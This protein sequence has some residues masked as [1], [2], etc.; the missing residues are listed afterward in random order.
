MLDLDRIVTDMLTSGDTE[1]DK[2]TNRKPEVDGMDQWGA[3]QN[4][5]RRDVTVKYI[6]SRHEGDNS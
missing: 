5:D 2:S 1:A 3:R 6:L 4:V